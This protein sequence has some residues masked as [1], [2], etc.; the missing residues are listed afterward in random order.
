MWHS[1]SGRDLRSR[2]LSGTRQRALWVRL[3]ARRGPVF[4]LASRERSLL[5]NY[6]QRV[7]AMII[8]EERPVDVAA[9]R[10][11]VTAAFERADEAS[12][13]AHVTP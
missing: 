6:T 2:V 7:G 5:T 9:I 3:R 13:G 12:L 4:A 1:H 11:T 8:R 10:D